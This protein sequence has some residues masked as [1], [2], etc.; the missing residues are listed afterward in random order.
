MNTRL[1]YI[2]VLVVRLIPA[3]LLT[4]LIAGFATAQILTGTIYGVVT[5]TT[6]AVVPG[7]KVTAVDMATSHAYTATTT[8]G[9]DYIIANIPYGHYKVTIE[10]KGFKSP[11]V[12]VL[13]E[14]IKSSQRGV[15]K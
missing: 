5:D 6:G 3:L 14:F 9:G 2:A 8:G 10:A 13:A 1:R 7:A 15:A 4:L 11:H 12:R